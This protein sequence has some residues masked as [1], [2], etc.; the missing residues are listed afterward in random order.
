[1]LYSNKI[2]VTITTQ[3]DQKYLAKSDGNTDPFNISVNDPNSIVT[4]NTTGSVNYQVR[5]F[6]NEHKTK[7]TL[8]QESVWN[9]VAVQTASLTA[10]IKI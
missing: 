7:Q 6:S 3:D 5:T 1:M 9:G 4:I 8:T 2:P 10:E